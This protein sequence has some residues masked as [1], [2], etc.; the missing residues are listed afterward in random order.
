MPT[1]ID[2]TGQTFG[3]LTAVERAGSGNSGTRWKCQCACGNVTES[4]VGS[5]RS[6]KA[7]SCG[8]SRSTHMREQRYQRTHGWSHKERLYHV[9]RGMLDRCNYPRHNRYDI[10]GGRGITVCPE[11][12]DYAAFRDWA[13]A[14]GYD[15]DAPRGACTIDRI[16]PDGD[17]C[18]ENCRWVD[19]K[20][21]ANNRRKE[22][23]A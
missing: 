21:Q 20:T 4:L 6:G 14:N 13:L 8:C 18:P 22:V 11:W 19:S 12:S 1:F 16:D 10:Y 2:L 5:L 17:Y 23:A 3:L 15:S 9:W 7:M